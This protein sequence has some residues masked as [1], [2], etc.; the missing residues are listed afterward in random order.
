MLPAPAGAQD[1]F[2]EV[3]GARLYYEVEGTGHPLVL[4]HGWPLSARMWDDQVRVLADHYRVVRYDRRGFGRSPANPWNESSAGHD[5]EDLAALLDHLSI[6]SAHVLGMSQG[7]SVATRFALEYPQR[8]DALM[9]H[10]AGLEGFVLPEHGP[11]ASLESVRTLMEEEGMDA[12]RR[13]WLAHPI[14]YIPDGKPEAS[15]RLRRIVEEYSGADMLTRPSSRSRE[16]TPAIQRLHEIRAP[17][18]VLVG[19]TDLPFFQII[20]DA[21]AFLIPD[22][23]KVVVPGGGHVV[24]MI[25]PERYNAEV[26]RFL[27]GIEEPQ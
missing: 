16:R 4:I 15:A 23:E 20:A 10:G 27:R 21:L 17:T 22:A 26:L 2:A 3:N 8:V 18:L 12:F 14:N 7:G 24:N 13:Q 19:D 25:E 9:L 1:S 6:S 11:F 5:F